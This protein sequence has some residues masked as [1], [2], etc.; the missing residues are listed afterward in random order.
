MQEFT[1]KSQR[2]RRTQTKSIQ[3]YE[4]KRQ[5]VDQCDSEKIME[6]VL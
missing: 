1:T 6:C 4:I 2:P 3:M 5:V